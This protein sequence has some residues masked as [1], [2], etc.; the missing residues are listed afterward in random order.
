MISAWTLS[1]TWGFV[2]P[3]LN[4]LVQ[5]L[6]AMGSLPRWLWG[7]LGQLSGR[8]QDAKEGGRLRLDS[9]PTQRDQ[10]C[11]FET[12]W[13]QCMDLTS[14]SGSSLRKG[15]KRCILESCGGLLGQN[16]RDPW[17]PAALS[18]WTEGLL[19]GSTSTRA[20]WI[21]MAAR[22]YWNLKIAPMRAPRCGGGGRGRKGIC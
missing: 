5:Q 11:P 18:C 19:P 14:T 9:I 15:G 22:A 16:M 2:C 3:W 7:G 1:W 13:S 4:I 8:V 20:A 17:A 6:K 12:T 21:S 10:C